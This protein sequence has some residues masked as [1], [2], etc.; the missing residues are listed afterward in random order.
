VSI[1]IL[2]VKTVVSAPVIET[3]RHGGSKLINRS[4]AEAHATDPTLASGDYYV[5]PDGIHNGDG[6]ISVYCDMST[7]VE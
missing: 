2:I 7:G 1:V 6:P 3:P 5:D 4:C